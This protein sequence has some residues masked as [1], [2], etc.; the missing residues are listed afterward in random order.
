MENC[1]YTRRVWSD[2]DELSSRS[3]HQHFAV[4]WKWKSPMI[5]YQLH[6][7]QMFQ[8]EHVSTTRTESRCGSQHEEICSWNCSKQFHVKYASREFCCGCDLCAIFHTWNGRIRPIKWSS[9]LKISPR[10]LSDIRSLSPMSC[11]AVSLRRAVTKWKRG[12]MRRSSKSIIR[13]G[14]EP[15][16][17]IENTYNFAW[18]F[19]LYRLRGSTSRSLSLRRRPTNKTWLLLKSKVLLLI[20]FIEL[21][22]RSRRNNWLNNLWL[23]YIE[24]ARSS[25]GQQTSSLSFD[26]D[27]ESRQG[28]KL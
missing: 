25:G 17:N 26:D 22:I 4:K 5:S 13:I 1:E 24:S 21:L 14:S 16:V 2:D 11:S 18:F 20:F 12:A 27:V 10:I 6:I 19:L 3:L 15:Q 8:E 7:S 9:Q 23:N 28:G